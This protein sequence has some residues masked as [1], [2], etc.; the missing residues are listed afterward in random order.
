AMRGSRQLSTEI[1]RLAVH[2]GRRTITA[3][4]LGALA[5][6]DF[7]P[8]C[9][10]LKSR[11]DPLPFRVFQGIFASIDS[12]TNGI[13][14]HH[15]NRHRASPWFAELGDVRESLEVPGHQL[16]RVHD[17]RTGLTLAGT[18]D[19]L[20]RRADGSYLIADY[21]TARHTAAQDRLLP[22]YEVQLNAYAYIA[23]RAGNPRCRFVPISG[24]ALIYVEPANGHSAPR[25]ARHVTPS[26]FTMAFA[27]K[28]VPVRLDTGRVPAL[29]ERARRI[30][31]AGTPPAAARWCTDCAQ[32]ETLIALLAGQPTTG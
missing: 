29:L 27:P 6:P 26:G 15:V 2:P 13:V 23:E 30:S 31:A 7:C 5:L 10:W 14:H 22:M 28:V 21:K 32:L 18:M 16:F 19:A 11:V 12:Y 8:R 25:A 20:F 1:K 9:F 4:D 17:Q 24:L 3:R